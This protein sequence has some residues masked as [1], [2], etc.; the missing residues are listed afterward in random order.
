[1]KLGIM[2]PYF[3][4]YIGYF[5]LLNAVDRFIVYDDVNY[6]KRG[7]INRNR[8]LMNGKDHL[9]TIPVSNA[10]QNDLIYETQVSNDP[11]WKPKLLKTL[12][13]AYKDAPHYQEVI[14][15]I[16]EVLNSSYNNM[17]ELAVNSLFSVRDFLGLETEVIRTS[18]QY[19]N[20]GLK[21]MHRILDI[22]KL[23]GAGTYINPAGGIDLYDKELFKNEGVNLQFI[24]P[25]NVTYVQGNNEFINNLSIIDV[26]MFNSKEDV[27]RLLAKYRLI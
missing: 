15:L 20:Q 1:M 8:I 9:I 12:M 26:L 25:E 7:W 14:G 4:P 11:K 10:S 19:S 2:Q 17:A 13:H 22:C 5:Q 6:I 18:T 23:E 27:I 16:E 3:F 21:G 24:T